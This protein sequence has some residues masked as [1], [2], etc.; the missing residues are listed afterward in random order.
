L[1]PAAAAMMSRAMKSMAVRSDV[2]AKSTRAEC[3][4]MR[5][6]EMTSD[7][8]PAA[9]SPNSASEIMSSMSVKPRVLT[10]SSWRRA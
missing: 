8:A 4:C 7:I 2:C 1:V 9:M 5:A 3:V 6:P 10:G